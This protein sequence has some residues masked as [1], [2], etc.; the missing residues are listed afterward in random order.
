MAIFNNNRKFIS[1][2]L[3]QKSPEGFLLMELMMTLLMISIFMMVILHYHVLHMQWR[4]EVEKRICA[5]NKA[6]T[7]IEEFFCNPASVTPKV[8]SE[9]GFAVHI[10]IR[11]QKGE[12][13][14]LAAPLKAVVDT[15]IKVTVTWINMMQAQQIVTLESIALV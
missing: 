7:L 14:L 2:Q 10:D 11:K 8:Y 3:L 9:D 5:L 4:S 15:Y 6:A 1:S 13:I 12:N